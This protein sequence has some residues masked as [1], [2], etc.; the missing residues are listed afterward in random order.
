MNLQI[1]KS[2]QGQPEFVLLPI[3]LYEKLSAKI[4]VEFFLDEDS[5]YVPFILEDYID[6]PVALARMKA[7]VTQK[8]LAKAM[9]VSQ[10]YI[11]KLEVQE[12]VT[13]KTLEK[14]MSALA[15]LKKVKK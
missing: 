9:A 14:A 5:E 3:K 8:A 11:S 6:N 1:I 2:T 13:A 12:K 10:A 4:N 15:K 7:N